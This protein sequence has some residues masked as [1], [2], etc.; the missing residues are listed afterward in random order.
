MMDEEIIVRKFLLWNF[1][2]EKEEEEIFYN[3]LFLLP[4]K[5]TYS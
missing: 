1:R 4:I 5:E 3:F 2:N